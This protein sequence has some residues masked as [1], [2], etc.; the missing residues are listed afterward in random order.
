MDGTVHAQTIMR[1]QILQIVY[2]DLALCLEIISHSPGHIIAKS[3]ESL[4]LFC[5]SNDPYLWCLWKHNRYIISIH[6]E[7]SWQN[8]TEVCPSTSQ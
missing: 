2:F 8:G 6:K 7:M 1:A 4:E 5:D 3:G